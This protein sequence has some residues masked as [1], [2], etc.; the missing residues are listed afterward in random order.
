MRRT[1]VIRRSARN[2]GVRTAVISSVISAVLASALTAFAM[3]RLM[4]QDNPLLQDALYNGSYTSQPYSYQR[5]RAVRTARTA[6]VVYQEPA[7]Y[8]EPVR[9]P[10]STG[11]S[12]LIVAGSAGAGAGI[13]ALA[14][15]KKGAAIGAISGGVAGLIYDR[16]TANR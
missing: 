4:N 16:L 5:P 8:Q 11:K 6:P 1:A 15:G 3:P 2:H 12:V 10:R 14:G 13:G 9:K 7:V